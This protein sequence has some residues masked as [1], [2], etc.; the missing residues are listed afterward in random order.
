MLG[1]EKKRTSTRPCLLYSKREAK[2][3]GGGQIS[4][5]EV[6]MQG[7]PSF[8]LLAGRDLWKQPSQAYL[9]FIHIN[10]EN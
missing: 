7:G 2:V 3:G 6:K 4:S 8:H 10:A 5:E 9:C 1:K